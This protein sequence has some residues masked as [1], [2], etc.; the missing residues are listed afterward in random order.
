MF[1]VRHKL[2][3]S[4]P[5]RIVLFAALGALVATC[6]PAATPMPTYTPLPTYTPFP[7]PEPAPTSPPQPTVPAEAAEAAGAQWSGIPVV[8]SLTVSPVTIQVG[9]T[10]TLYWGRVE[11]A[12]AAVLVTPEGRLG[13][14]TP[15]QTE[16]QPNQTTTYSLY[17]FCGGTVVQQRVTVNVEVPAGCS[18]VPDIT[19]FAADPT[20][21]Q[22]GRTSTLKWGS[23]ENASAA[24]LVSPEGKEG[25]GTPGE[26]IV[27][28]NQTTTYALVA[29]CGSDVVQKNVTLTV[30]GT[31]ACSGAPPISSFTANPAAIQKGESSA[32]EWGL[33]ANAN[34]AYLTDGEEL[35]GVATPGQQVVT[36]EQTTTYALAA[37][38]GSSIVESN[39]TITVE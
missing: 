22:P 30:E 11:N 32:L 24:V 7:T 1:K 17:A 33:V 13:V 16:V 20:T 4:V 6:G 3:G 12:R 34:G 14:A 18:G 26:M 9:E 2:R 8:T 15:G 10:A 23:V 28:P 5:A 25:V 29:F 35:T 38:C 19:A 21:V 39:V 36:P 27:G 31:T 37:F